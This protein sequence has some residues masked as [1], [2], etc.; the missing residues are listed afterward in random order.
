MFSRLF[1]PRATAHAHCD[2]PCGV[3]DPA[4]AKLE[5]ES[6]KATQEKYQANEDPHFRARAIIIKEQRAEAVKHHISV[7]W[8]DYFKAPHFEKYPQLHQLINDTL[9]AASAAKA[10]TDPATGQALLDLI[11]EVD[12]IF[13]ETKQA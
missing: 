5:A 8:S 13:W 3:Y 12:K 4:Q 6:V 10:S 1:A 7:L 2:L 11:A 9:K